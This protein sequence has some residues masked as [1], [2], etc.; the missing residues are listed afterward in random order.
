MAFNLKVYQ[1]THYPFGHPWRGKLSKGSES[2]L[3]IYTSTP[4]GDCLK[5]FMTNSQK[6]R[7]EEKTREQFS[8]LNK[9]KLDIL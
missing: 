3:K 5:G 6:E 4:E 8:C 1:W 7:I 9:K 2:A